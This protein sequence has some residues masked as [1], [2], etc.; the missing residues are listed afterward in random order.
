MITFVAD[1]AGLTVTTAPAAGF[2]QLVIRPWADVNRLMLAGADCAASAARARK[3]IVEDGAVTDVQI[4]A[5]VAM[6]L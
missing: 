2:Q 1:K 4:P 5:P 6:T 3:T